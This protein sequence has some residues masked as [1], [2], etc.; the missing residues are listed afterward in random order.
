M[1]PA[2]SPTHAEDSTDARVVRTR[3]AV[4]RAATDLLVEGGPSAVTIDAVVARSGVAKSTI[5][6][7]WES[8]DDVLVAVV[9]GCA[10]RIEPPEPELGFEGGLRLLVDEFRRMLADP[11]WARILPA[12]LVLKTHQD[13]IADLEQQLEENQE[14]AIEA[15]LRRG[16]EEGHLAP[17]FDLEEASALIVGP[18]LFAHLVGKP[19]VDERLCHHVV[20][21][22]LRTHAAG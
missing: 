3:A 6:R 17:D 8:R 20:D 1:G 18:L 16:V 21:V 2:P 5:Y 10:P 9:R 4:L 12:L 13:G 22:F 14:H 19:P 11:D 15:V 7:H